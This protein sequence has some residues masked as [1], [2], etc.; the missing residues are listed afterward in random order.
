MTEDIEKTECDRCGTC[1]TKG[2][3]AL[4]YQDLSLLQNNQLT[5]E[6]LITVRKGEPVLLLSDENPRPTNAEIVK[7]KGKA[8]G[9]TCIFFEEKESRC[10]IYEHRPLEC[11]LLKCWETADL[12]NMAGENLLTRYDIID[13]SA[14]ILPFIENHE[15]KCSLANLGQLLSEVSL[16]KWHRKALGQLTDLVNTDLSIR[17]QAYD[18]F[19]FSLELELFYFGRPLFKILEQ[20]GIVAHEKKGALILSVSPA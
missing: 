9:W 15:A 1:C 3:P 19:E 17:V 6:H 18:K 10:A 5:L 4:H 14:P 11:S 7:I 12:E 16:K 2:G 13:S 8:S 20:F